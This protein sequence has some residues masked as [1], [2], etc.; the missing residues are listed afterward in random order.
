MD[1]TM[2]S[3]GEP[4][5]EIMIT[6][7]EKTENNRGRKRDEV[8]W[9]ELEIRRL[10]NIVAECIHARRYVGLSKEA[11]DERKRM[12]AYI[13]AM[14]RKSMRVLHKA[15]LFAKSGYAAWPGIDP[16]ITDPVSLAEEYV[17]V[18]QNYEAVLQEEES[19]AKSEENLSGIDQVPIV[20]EDWEAADMVAYKE[21]KKQ[22]ETSEDSNEK[23]RQ[24]LL[25]LDAAGMRRR[26]NIDAS[27]A[28]TSSKLTKE[29]E[30]FM[31]KHQPIQDE[32]T[33][34]LV[35]LVGNLKETISA[36]QGTLDQDKQVIDETEDV[37]DK[38]LSGVTSQ[39]QSL[40][41]YANTTAS[42]WW[43]IP[44]GVVMI[45]VFVIIFV[46]IRML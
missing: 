13:D 33:N 22:A 23:R 45:I 42:W 34:N 8:F 24:D 27:G 1:T 10:G 20:E 3:I 15:E 29:E 9:T 30:E 28:G 35:E 32:L 2:G 36:T 38:N 18:V 43:M 6:S 46:L 26:K 11:H 4:S 39:Q 16:T 41:A 37:V 14:K 5:S 19:K 7:V 44:L 12:R 40:T 25:G 21:A 17:N 31:S